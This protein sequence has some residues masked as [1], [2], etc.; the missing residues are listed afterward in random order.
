[1]DNKHKFDNMKKVLMAI[2]I[3]FT[4]GIA[5]FNANAQTAKF[6]HIDYLEVVD[7]IPTWLDANNQLDAF[8][9]M[10]QKTIAD[11]EKD[12]QTV[13]DVYLAEKETLSPLLIEYREKEL[14]EKQ[15]LLEY[16]KQALENDLQIWNQRLFL[17]IEE[18]LKKAI[19]TI[20]LKFGITYMF[21]KSSMLY[22]APTVSLDLTK[23]VRIEL[24][25]LEKIRVPGL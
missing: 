7:S 18:N 11:M 13:Y 5:G 23:E 6:A 25:R 9:A 2:V 4:L 8:I 15:E 22:I 12:L 17:P 19:E 21:E 10:G 20:A 16:K 1:M 3:I 24:I 14:I